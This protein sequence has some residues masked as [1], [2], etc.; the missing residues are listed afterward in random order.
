MKKPIRSTLL[1]AVMAMIATSWMA[2]DSSSADE[3]E[4][5]GTLSG[6]VREAG[7]ETPLSDITVQLGN[8]QTTTD[9]D[10]RFAFQE[11]PVGSMTLQVSMEGFDAYTQR[12]VV[13]AGDNSVDISLVRTSYYEFSPPSGGNY[14]LYLPPGVSTYR[15]VIFLVAP[16]TRDS[17]GFASGIPRVSPPPGLNENV[18]A[19]RQRSL[20]LAEKYG[21]AL[22]GA[23]VALIGQ[24]SDILPVL[25][26]FAEDTGHPELAQA[27]LLV[28]GFSFGGCFAYEFT[29]GHTE[30][31]IGFMTQK[32]GC[33]SQ[34]DTG[35]ARLVPGYLFIGETDTF[36]RA[37][38]ITQLFVEN[39]SQGALWALAIEPGAGHT[40]VSDYTLLSNWMDTVLQARLPE[41]VSP[42][43]SV[44]LKAIDEA[45]GWL[46]NRGSSSIAEYACYDED[47][48]RASWLP[49]MQIAQDWQAFV[50]SSSVT[51]VTP[52]SNRR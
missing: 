38:E 34:Q 47:R 17:R 7:T 39:R 16:S 31:V 44:T 8:V 41:T 26:Q 48:L 13:E 30:R 40:S 15:G 2:C 45:S 6:V 4:S 14:G 29:L 3:E 22:M 32:G 5:P 1:F 10:G 49:S 36:N 27:P 11:V 12:I 25:D 20:L 51:T 18:A 46:G 24:Q 37:E 19:V 21:L 28:M 50:S 9:Q 43:A 35:L 52:C 23:Q 42:G 33:H